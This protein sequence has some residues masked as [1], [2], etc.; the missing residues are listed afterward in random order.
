MEMNAAATV[1]QPLPPEPARA[2]GGLILPVALFAAVLVVALGWVISRA[3]AEGAAITQLEAQAATEQARSQRLALVASHVERA[4]RARSEFQ[5]R[6][7]LVDRLRQAQSSTG[8]PLLALGRAL[9]A[10][11]AVRIV[12]I[13]FDQRGMQVRGEASAVAASDQFK[14]E[15]ERASGMACS[16]AAAAGAETNAAGKFAWTCKARAAQ[17]EGGRAK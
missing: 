8:A 3:R 2:S 13:G 14:A 9:R 17:A 7:I 16:P 10:G 5:E 11:A 15:L 6:V 4:D 1:R 12:T